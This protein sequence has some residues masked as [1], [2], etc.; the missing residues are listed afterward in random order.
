MQNIQPRNLSDTEL[1]RYYAA[2]LDSGEGVPVNWQMELLRRFNMRV[3]PSSAESF[4]T[5]SYV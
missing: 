5:Y 3:T 4:P 2:Q 1:I